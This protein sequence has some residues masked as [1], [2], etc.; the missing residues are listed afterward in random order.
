MGRASKRGAER[1]TERRAIRAESAG[2]KPSRAAERQAV[3]A[4]LATLAYRA[5]VAGLPSV[6]LVLDLAM[7]MESEDWPRSGPRGD[8]VN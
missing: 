7:A 1:A 6:A 4:E 2:P 3:L 8:A 5:R